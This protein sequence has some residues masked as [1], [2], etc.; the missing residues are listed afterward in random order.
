MG[1]RRPSPTLLK[2]GGA[3]LTDKRGDEAVRSDVLARLAAEIARWPGAA[4]GRL[5]IAHGSGSF[6]HRAAARSGFLDDPANPAAFAAVAASAARLHRRVVDA[7]IAAGLP[8]VGVPGGALATLDGGVVVEVRADLVARMLAA[9]LLPVT[10]GDAALDRSRG[11]GIASTEPLLVALADGLGAT[12]LVFATDVD[13]VYDRDPAAHPDARPFARL[14]AGDVDALEL[15]GAG[16]EAVDV[17]G[18]MRSKVGAALA[19]VGRRPD[20]TVRILSG[21]RKGAV[22]AALADDPGAGGT[23]VV[24]VGA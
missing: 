11:G 7:L 24:A 15:G 13:G 17:T 6:A 1:V 4:D 18:G 14:S 10:Y 3:L 23:L 12:H 22:A 20:V 8:A 19:L 21:G 16:P 5:V 9:G 2:L